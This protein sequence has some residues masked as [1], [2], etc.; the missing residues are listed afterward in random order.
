MKRLIFLV[1][2]AAANVAAV[3]EENTIQLDANEQM[4]LDNLKLRLENANLQVQIFQDHIQS[5]Q[6]ALKTDSIQFGD[7]V[8][9]AH[10]NPSGVTWDFD[11]MHFVVA[12]K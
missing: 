8:L 7:S 1:V 3:S 11:K 2:L 10:G 9:K 4:R 12:K 5:V 6:N